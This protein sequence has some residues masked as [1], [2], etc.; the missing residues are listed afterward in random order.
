MKSFTIFNLPLPSHRPLNPILSKVSCTSQRLVLTNPGLFFPNRR[1]VK[2][3]PPLVHENPVRAKCNFLASHT[4]VS[5]GL[6]SWGN[7]STSPFF[8]SLS[9]YI[10]V[11][12]LEQNIHSFMIGMLHPETQRKTV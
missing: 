5:N 2:R 9:I 8:P 11:F 1:L 10:R 4:L 12:P 3:S 6:M 7:P